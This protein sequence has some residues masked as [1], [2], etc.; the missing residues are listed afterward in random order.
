VKPSQPPKTDRYGDPLPLGVA[1]RLGTIR[2]RGA[3]F[4]KHIVYS[5]DGRI[6]VTDSGERRLHVREAQG[7]K[8]LRQLDLGIEDIRDFAFSADGRS[9]AAVG[10]QLEPKRNVLVNHLTFN[11]LAAGRSA[12]R[13]GTTCKLS[14]RSPTLPMTR[15]LRA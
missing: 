7:G 9:I 15:L 4:I 3:P 10:I 14:K 5:P 12:G 1:M 6:V 8:E 13:N 2:F 11:D